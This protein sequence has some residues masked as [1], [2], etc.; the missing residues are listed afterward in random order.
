MR[1]LILGATAFALAGLAP[2]ATTTQ[3]RA[4]IEYPYCGYGR[5]GSGGCM[6]ATLD[7]CRAFVSG[8]GGACY[9]NPRYTANAAG[10][11]GTARTRR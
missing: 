6:Y 1:N 8:A 7:Q 10:T 4:E 2:L 11:A 3:A 9:N 5:Q